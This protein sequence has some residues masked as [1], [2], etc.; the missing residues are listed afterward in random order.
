MSILKDNGGLLSYSMNA[1]I[2]PPAKIP[3]LIGSE[4]STCFG[5]TWKGGAA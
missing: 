2:Q 3:S 5:A 1:V 4:I